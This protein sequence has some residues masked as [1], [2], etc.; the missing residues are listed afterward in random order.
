VGRWLLACVLTLALAGPAVGMSGAAADEPAV[1]DKQPITGIGVQLVEVPTSA[2]DDPRARL[3]IIDRLAPGSLIHRRIQVTNGTPLPVKVALY[4]SA[5]DV[6]QG[7]FLTAAGHSQNELSTWTSVSPRSLDLAPREKALTAVRVR[8]PTD[9]APG[10]SYGVVWAQVSTPPNSPGGVRQVS[11]AGIRLYLSIGPGNAPA[12]DF[13]IESLTAGRDINGQPTVTASTRNTGGRALDLT[14]QLRLTHGPGG[15]AAG[16]FPASSGNTVGINQ[17]HQVTV[18]LDAQVPNGPWQATLTMTSGLLKRSAHATLTFPTEAGTT[19][20]EETPSGAVPRWLIGAATLLL[21]V[22]LAWM[23]IVWR[24]RRLIRRTGR[25]A[26][27]AHQ[28][29]QH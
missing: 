11:R 5:A 18:P 9:A 23:L 4:A 22:A 27:L 24:R 7:R 25:Q 1:R 17:T 10:E 13:R 26:A 14:G 3:Y 29:A 12:S 19:A 2:L 6:S 8:V 16:P 28:V 21:L 20:P 15:L